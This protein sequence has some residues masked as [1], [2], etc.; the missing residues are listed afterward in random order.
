MSNLPFA[1]PSPADWRALA[2][3][4]LKDRDLASLVHLD[5]DGLDVRPLYAAANAGEAVT[6]PR[7]THADGRAWDLRVLVEGNDAVA[8]NGVAL[9]QLEGGAASLLVRGGVTADSDTLVQTLAGVQ[10]ELAEVAL[11]AGLDGATAADALAVAAKGSP[12]AKLAFH[13]DPA[14]AFV[15]QGGGARPLRALLRRPGCAGNAL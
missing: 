6:A 14:S 2:E 11:D 15:A 10:L 12:R 7:P 3:T 9:A 4:A 13:M 1:T 5:A 8:L